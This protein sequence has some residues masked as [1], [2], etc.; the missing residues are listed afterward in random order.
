M[1]RTGTGGPALVR[2][3]S[4]DLPDPVHGAVALAC[5]FL[6]GPAAPRPLQA[7]AKRK[8]EQ[9]RSPAALALG[10]YPLDQTRALLVGLLQDPD[11][12]VRSQAALSLGGVEG[13]EI[14]EALLKQLEDPEEVARAAATAALGWRTD[15]RLP[16][17]LLTR[18]GQDRSDLVRLRAVGAL[19]AFTDKPS[20]QALAKA[21]L[22]DRAPR[23]RARAV[24]SLAAGAR[25][26]LADVFEKAVQDP[27]PSVADAAWL[28]LA[29]GGPEELARREAALSPRA[30]ARDRK[31][32]YGRLVD[33]ARR[34]RIAWHEVDAAFERTMLE[35]SRIAIRARAAE[36]LYQRY[37]G[38]TGQLQVP[39][40]RS[41][42]PVGPGPYPLILDRVTS[43][44]GPDRE[45]LKLWLED[46]PYLGVR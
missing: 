10:G 28:A 22:E 30:R 19:V 17:A 32:P 36:A 25:V 38:L 33:A 43:E 29:R 13:R 11:A 40:R 3:L 27:D 45:D 42:V 4:E 12:Q 9:L 24:L 21:A 5:G 23:V 18:L 16:A 2:E 1:A 46:R 8:E 20:T 39:A 15:Q 41:E 37:L 34:G 26:L 6:G 7:L 44:L 14:T 31:G 35:P